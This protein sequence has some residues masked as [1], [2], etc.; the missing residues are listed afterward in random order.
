MSVTPIRNTQ[1]RKRKHTVTT[2]QFGNMKNFRD[3]KSIIR[4][5]KIKLRQINFKKTGATKNSRVKNS[6]EIS[7]AS[8]KA[9]K[10]LMFRSFMSTETKKS[11]KS[12][13][14]SRGK[15]RGTIKIANNLGIIREENAKGKGKNMKL[16]P[17]NSNNQ[18]IL[19]KLKGKESFLT[20]DRPRDGI[21]RPTVMSIVSDESERK[22]KI[23]SDRI[24]TSSRKVSSRSNQKQSHGQG[25][26]NKRYGTSYSFDTS[27]SNSDK[28][29]KSS[30]YIIED[31]E[32][33]EEKELANMLKQSYIRRSTEFDGKGTPNLTDNISKRRAS[34]ARSRESFFIPHMFAKGIFVSEILEV[35]KQIKADEGKAKAIAALE[36]S[37][38]LNGN[39]QT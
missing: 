21:R 1:T 27:V 26:E 29:G 22:R 33:E 5:R 24:P 19:K 39:F 36:V 31:D 30:N 13:N 32:L 16:N 14:K 34:S 17:Y 10:D 7:T 8:Q 18:K 11:K 15:Q 28:D 23:F 37:E 20:V 38:R 3:S 6:S 12:R 4:K 35:E 2:T 25:S 9:S